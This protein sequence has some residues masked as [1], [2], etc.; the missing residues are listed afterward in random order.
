LTA[1]RSG[2]VLSFL[3]LGCALASNTP[4]E[5]NQADSEAVAAAHSRWFAGLL[6]RYD[7]LSDV[8]AQEVTLRFPGGNQMPRAEFL[9]LLQ[10]T[11]LVY[12]SAEH[13]AT[14]I[15]V[16]GGTGVVTGS[17]TLELRYKGAAQSERLAYTAVYVRSNS[18]WTLVAWQSTVVQP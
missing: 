15:R 12:D 4:A 2:V 18:K 8:L 10:T 3:S 7:V 14:E 9:S 17:S 16:Y 6:G 13:H 11:D 1:A 5:P